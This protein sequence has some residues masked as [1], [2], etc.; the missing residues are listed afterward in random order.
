MQETYLGSNIPKLGFG[1]MRLPKTGSDIDIE[2]T[3]QMVDCFLAQGFTYFDTA[4][5]YEGGRSEM[6]VKEVLA[7]RHPRESY[8]IA[9]KLPVFA[10]KEEGDLQRMFDTHLERMGT[11]YIDFY[12]L[13]SLNKDRVDDLEKWG[14]WQ[15]IQEKKRQG[16]VKHIG[17]SF[18][19]DAETL[20]KLLCAHPETEFVQLQ[21]NYADWESDSIQ[22][23]LCY[24]VAMKHGKPV[25]IMEPVKGGALAALPPHIQQTF[26]AANPAASIASWAVRYAASLPGVIT[27]LS[28]MSDLEQ[29]QD[30][31]GY[32][33]QFQPLTPAERAVVEQAATQLA[34]IPTIP[35]TRCRYCVDDCPQHINIP[36][37]FSAFNNYKTY[38]NLAGAKSTYDRVT[39]DGGPASSCLACGACE[40]HCPQHIQIIEELKNAAAVL[41]G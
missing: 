16:L 41:E 12:L 35:C 22:S 1:L 28:G 34:A 17:F 23:R 27:V 13:H 26:K 2:Q 30:N 14:V 18:H 31:T 39:K 9:T 29:M 36:E 3:K 19:D 21:I 5:V 20:D 32:M 37:I 40:G 6:A 33:A 7:T 15:F 10:V 38:N 24:E 11:G 4:Y 25:I 8:Q